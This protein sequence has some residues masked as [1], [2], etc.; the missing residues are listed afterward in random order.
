MK[1]EETFDIQNCTTQQVFTCVRQGDEYIYIQ[2]ETDRNVMP[3]EFVISELKNRFY[4][5]V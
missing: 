2:W 3:T 4:S 1:V 5:V